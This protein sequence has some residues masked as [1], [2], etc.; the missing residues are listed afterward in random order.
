LI[1][2][3]SDVELSNRQSSLGRSLR[4]SFAMW[5]S[6][7]AAHFF[8][9]PGGVTRAVSGLWGVLTTGVGTI[10]K[11]FLGVVTKIGSILAGGFSA[12]LSAAGTAFA[13]LITPMGLLT[14]G[15]VGLTAYLI[16]SSGIWK[17]WFDA[18]KSGWENLKTDA[19]AAFG[20]IRSALAAG[21]IAAAWQVIVTLLKLE[22]Q[23]ATGYM[24]GRWIEFKTFVLDVWNNASASLATFFV[25]ALA[26]IESAWVSTVGFLDSVWTGFL[27][28]F[29]T[30]WQKSINA[31]AGPIAQMIAWW[32]GLDP[33]DVEAELRDIQKFENAKVT[34][35]NAARN[36][37]LQGRQADR[38]ARQNQIESD[39]QSNVSGI[40]DQRKADE[41][42]RR[43]AA[44]AQLQQ[45]EDDLKNARINF[46]EAVKRANAA[47][48]TST[49]EAAR[50]KAAGAVQGEAKLTTTGTFSAAAVGGLGAES[51][52][53]RTA[54]ASEETAKN[55][56][57]LKRQQRQ[58]NGL[59]VGR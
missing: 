31:L 59:K 40:E 55:T 7:T 13:Y 10:A 4:G 17:G 28:F 15:L 22:W 34:S 14:A 19:L 39:R 56:R 44:D 51:A 25:N 20:G 36:E 47:G 45:I 42:T 21:D 38:T 52:A 54:R 12:A 5:F 24:M 30:S 43:A 18:L 53:Q 50:K 27:N 35:D 11:G 49:E 3:P 16:Y 37:K 8:H 9:E 32:Q 41:N 48:Q 29:A 33:A 58:G 6:R 46:D 57:D 23:R 26:G 2:S 1:T